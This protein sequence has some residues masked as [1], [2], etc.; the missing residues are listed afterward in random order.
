MSEAQCQQVIGDP[1]LTFWLY[2]ALRSIADIF[3]TTAVTLLDA[4]VVIATRETSC[5][6]GDVGRQLA[7]GSLGF[8]VFGPL[9]G[10]LTILAE[11]NPPS[12]YLPITMFS[13][14]MIISAFIALFSDGMPLSPP[15]WWWHTR[16]GMLALPM[17][18]IKRY[19][20]ETAALVFV[21]VIMG[22]LWSAMDTFLPWYNYNF[23]QFFPST[24]YHSEKFLNK[25]N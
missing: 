10:Y 20:S 4:A 8:A 24:F 22:I 13:V 23:I 17:S 11:G 5:G 15:E 2:L 21:L 3:P 16:S 7:F 9:T 25:D 6:R 18:A 12:Y 1:E 14:M 19:G